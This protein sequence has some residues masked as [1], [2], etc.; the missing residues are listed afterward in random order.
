MALHSVQGAQNCKTADGMHTR[1]VPAGRGNEPKVWDQP[2]H[3]DAEFHRVVQFLT[4]SED[5]S[6][7]AAALAAGALAAAFTVGFVSSSD[8][9]AKKLSIKP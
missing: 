5:S 3:R 2:I 8:C 7:F 4:S 6:F 9:K 1:S